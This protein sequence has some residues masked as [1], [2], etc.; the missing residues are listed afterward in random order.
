MLQ[1]SGEQLTHGFDLDTQSRIGRCIERLVLVEVRPQVGLLEEYAHDLMVVVVQLA[2]RLTLNA[3]FYFAKLIDY[4][5]D[6]T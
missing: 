5:R 3:A 1:N 6:S 2:E 4:E